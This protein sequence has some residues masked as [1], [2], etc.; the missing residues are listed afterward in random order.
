[1]SARP[2]KAW[3]PWL[4][5]QRHGVM[6]G[7]PCECMK[8]GELYARTILLEVLHREC[9]ERIYGTAVGRAAGLLYLLCCECR[10]AAKLMSW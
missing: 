5:H 6:I 8:P 2:L 1:V 9:P 3:T 4:V 7:L 10:V